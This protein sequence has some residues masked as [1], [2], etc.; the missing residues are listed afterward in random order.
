MK[1]EEVVL[2]IQ[3][4][5]AIKAMDV[6]IKELITNIRSLGDNTVIAQAMAVLF[7]SS[8]QHN[9]AMI[10]EPSDDGSRMFIPMIFQI[11]YASPVEEK[12]FKESVKEEGY[13]LEMVSDGKIEQ[14]GTFNERQN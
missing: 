6:F 11:V 3:Q 13:D 5:A 10:S 8:H 9:A 12:D 7:E 14:Q 4:D 2:Q 1:Y